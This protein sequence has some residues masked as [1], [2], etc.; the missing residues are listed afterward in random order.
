MAKKKD[1][2]KQIKFYRSRGPYGYMSNLSHW[3]VEF[4]GRKFMTAEHAYQF[5]KSS[6]P[7]IAEW[8]ATAPAGRLCAL[9]AHALL[10]YD[11]LPNWKEI[12]L[13]RMERV[14]RAKFTQNKNLGELLV[15]TGDAELIEE[16][17]DPYWGCGPMGGGAN[18]LGNILM[19][20]RS[21]RRTASA[22]SGL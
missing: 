16:S 20:V 18:H 11:V 9:T 12:R 21:E 3:A 6:K 7:W 4:E 15:A 22:F 5:G 13:E 17:G 8:L 1:E 2:R 14:V 19:K 10:P